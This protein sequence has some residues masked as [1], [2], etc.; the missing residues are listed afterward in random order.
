MNDAIQP[1][2]VTKLKKF[3]ILG[4][5]TILQIMLLLGSLGIAATIVY[6]MMA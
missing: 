5:F 1:E 4:K 2:L 3:R 6:Q